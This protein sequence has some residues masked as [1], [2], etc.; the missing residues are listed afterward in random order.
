MSRVEELMPNSTS[1]FQ[2][3]R[4]KIN[5]RNSRFTCQF[6][7]FFFLPMYAKIF[8]ILNKNLPLKIIWQLLQL[9]LNNTTTVSAF[10]HQRPQSNQIFTPRR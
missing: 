7:D 8:T 4:D 10:K 6:E 9:F 1:F 3:A 2:S 5:L